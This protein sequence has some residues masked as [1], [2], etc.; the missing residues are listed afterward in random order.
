MMMDG[1]INVGEYYDG[2][3]ASYEGAMRGIGWYMPEKLA[4]VLA[5]NFNVGSK[6]GLVLCKYS[7]LPLK[8][9]RI[10]E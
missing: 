6:T 5:I 7:K 10:P 3:V 4:E 8:S 9:V 2:F 1:G